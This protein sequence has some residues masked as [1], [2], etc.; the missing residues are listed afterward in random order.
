MIK[1]LSSLLATLTRVSSKT[2]IEKCFFDNASIN[3]LLLVYLANDIKRMTTP[4]NRLEFSFY[5]EIS[6]LYKIFFGMSLTHPETAYSLI[7]YHRINFIKELINAIRIAGIFNILMNMLRLISVA[8]ST[9]MVEEVPAIIF[10]TSIA[11]VGPQIAALLSKRMI[12]HSN[13]LTAQQRALLQPWYHVM[14]RIAVGF[15]PKV[16]SINNGIIYQYPKLTGSFLLSTREKIPLT[17]KITIFTENH[18]VIKCLIDNE[19]T[20]QVAIKL[21]F[22]STSFSCFTVESKNSFINNLIENYLTKVISETEKNCFATH[23]DAF[24][25]TSN[26]MQPYRNTILFSYEF[27]KELVMS[28]YAHFGFV[29]GGIQD[30]CKKASVQ[31]CIQKIL[32]YPVE[33]A[34]L[35]Q[36][37]RS[38]RPTD[39]VHS[40]DFSHQNKLSPATVR[41]ILYLVA[42]RMPNVQTLFLN[43][44]SDNVTPYILEP[45]KKILANLIVKSKISCLDLSYQNLTISD[46]CLFARAFS[47]STINALALRGNHIDELSIQPLLQAKVFSRL[48][49]VDFRDNELNDRAAYFLAQASLNQGVRVLDLSRNKIGNLGA[50]YLG[51]L[52][53]QLN[54]LDLR[55]NPITDNGAEWLAHSIQNSSLTIELTGNA[56]FYP[57]A[58]DV[59]HFLSQDYP[60]NPHW[61]IVYLSKDKISSETFWYILDILHYG[62]ESKNN[63]TLQY[64]IELPSVEY[65]DNLSRF[66]I[67]YS[68]NSICYSN[69]VAYVSHGNH[70]YSPG[71]VISIFYWLRSLRSGLAHWVNNF[72]YLI[73]DNDY[74]SKKEYQGAQDMKVIIA[75]NAGLFYFYSRYLKGK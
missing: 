11:L 61:N 33:H 45:H 50:G 69:D 32:K 27:V 56:A 52:I 24:N 15:I 23:L 38:I 42:W 22:H 72:V 9:E 44:S 18:N 26:S 40:L 8:I 63:P 36:T 55:E 5:Y 12:K 64:K 58:I 43:A 74:Y 70:R 47:R 67:P 49:L 41:K 34:E 20:H 53:P 39:E 10:Y 57:N 71:P 62:D 59:T 66:S 46:F 7:K 16:D 19:L 2:I 37:L 68:N 1:E 30:Y 25:S 73:S 28:I 35:I 29:N 4:H 75:N 21:L 60:D 14:G 17:T 54:F 48:R 51:Q 3:S 31:N 65:Q 6:I 13:K